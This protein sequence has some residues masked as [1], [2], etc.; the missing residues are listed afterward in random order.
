MPGDGEALKGSVILVTS[1]ESCHPDC[2]VGPLCGSPR[3]Q[4]RATASGSSLTSTAAQQH[5]LRPLRSG[6]TVDMS[7]GPPWCRWAIAID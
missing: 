5:P 1:F 7:D 6:P 4:R 3:I 2:R